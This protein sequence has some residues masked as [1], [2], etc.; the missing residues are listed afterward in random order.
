MDP[1]TIA[2]ADEPPPAPAGDPTPVCTFKGF[3][4]RRQHGNIRKR[5][6]EDSAEPS[7]GNEGGS[8]VIRVLKA[9][10]ESALGFSTAG[11]G[12]SHRT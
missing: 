5:E 4:K 11:A 6:I 8:A 9:K 1:S 2:I 3:N 10:K 12:S 7:S